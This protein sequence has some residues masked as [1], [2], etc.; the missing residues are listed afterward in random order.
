VR[1]AEIVGEVGPLTEVATIVRHHHERV[2]GRGYPDA[3]C[4]AMIPEFARIIA[5]A[6]AY[7]AMTADRAYRNALSS[8]EAQE[9][10]RENLGAQFDTQ[11]GLAFL[12]LFEAPEMATFLAVA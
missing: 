3:L 11:F 6:D 8:V 10:I 9:L 12:E 5:L 4:G 7:E 1:S 2:D